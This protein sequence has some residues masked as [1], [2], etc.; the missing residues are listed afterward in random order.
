MRNFID[1]L[2]LVFSF[3]TRI[4]VPSKK[5]EDRVLSMSV[6]FLPLVG[7]VIGTAESL[8]MFLGDKVG[9]PGLVLA[10]FYL[11]IPILITGGIHIDGFIDTADAMSSYGSIE[12][13]HK[14]LKDPRVGAFGIIRLVLYF[15]VALAVLV[16][17]FGNNM[18]L[19]FIH[20]AV[21]FTMPFVLSRVLLEV[22]VFWYKPYESPD[23]EGG[24]LLMLKAGETPVMKYVALAEVVVAVV[25]LFL[26]LPTFKA[27]ATLILLAGF[28]L[29]FRYF[30]NRYFAGVSGDLCG[31]FLCIAEL[32]FGIGVII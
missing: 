12:K 15:L 19:P 8:M 20:A 28:M 2:I 14:I 11:A 4:P 22:I 16:M 7:I 13:K 23:G 25:V 5:A 29:Y 31:W 24:M 18:N 26:A 27:M 30:A 6:L 21:L 10:L 1:A 32:I 3:F 9:L 17:L